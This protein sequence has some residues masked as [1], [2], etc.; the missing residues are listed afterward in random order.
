MPVQS[1]VLG[2]VMRDTNGVATAP[3][4]V[5]FDATGTA[6]VATDARFFTTD[7]APVATFNSSGQLVGNALG[8]VQVIGQ[9][10]RLQT[11]SIQVTVISSPP[12][13]LVNNVPDSAQLALPG[14]KDSASSIAQLT[15]AVTVDAVDLTTV[16]GVLVTYTLSPHASTQ[17]YMAVYLT[18]ASNT[19]Q[20]KLVDTTKVGGTSS[21]NLI[22]IGSALPADRL[23]AGD[24][25]VVTISAK[26]KGAPLKGAPLTL[27][28]P[29]LVHF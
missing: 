18:D 22:V 2:D 4:L 11:P 25:A 8:T 26:Y 1:V 5:E 9:I 20:Q 16:P 13:S 6:T 28:I 24:T 27:K 21:R 19:P 14:T 12:D 15:L 29:I 23:V 7:T 10:G 3:S 17:K